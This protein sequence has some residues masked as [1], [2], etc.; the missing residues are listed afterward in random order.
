MGYK[1]FFLSIIQKN[2]ILF[3][4][5]WDII[6]CLSPMIAS[7][8]TMICSFMGYNTKFMTINLAI[9]G[10]N[11]KIKPFIDRLFEKIDL[12]VHD[13]FIPAC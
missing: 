2:I 8:M 13:W 11:I 10:M 5:L 4:L 7:F 6:F 3:T 1:S 9:I 12:K